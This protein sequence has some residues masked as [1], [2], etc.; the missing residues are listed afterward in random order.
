[1]GDLSENGLYKAARF[2]LSQIDR[3]IRFYKNLIKYGKIIV[4]ENYNF[5]QIGHFVTLENDNKTK[6]YQI[7]GEYEADPGNNKISYKSPIGHNLM[8]HK[9]GEK[10]DIRIPS[11]KIHFVIK[12][13]N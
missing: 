2:E 5:V 4:L 1:M 3:Q 13:L 12:N 6:T 7:V 11:G 8:G 10:V 9:I